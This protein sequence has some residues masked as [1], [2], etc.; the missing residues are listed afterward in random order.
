[1]APNRRD[2]RVRGAGHLSDGSCVITYD[3]PKLLRKTTPR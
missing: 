1:L 2:I 3:F